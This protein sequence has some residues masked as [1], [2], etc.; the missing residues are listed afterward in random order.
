MRI[1]DPF[2]FLVLVVLVVKEERG[3]DQMDEDWLSEY[4]EF[5]TPPGSH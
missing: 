5:L 1:R 2:P 3:A 4:E